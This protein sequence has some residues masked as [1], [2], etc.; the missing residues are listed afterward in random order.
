MAEDFGVICDGG[1]GRPLDLL[2]ERTG[3]EPTVMVDSIEDP[4]TGDHHTL[5]YCGPC[6]ERLHPHGTLLPPDLL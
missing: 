3:L 4:F 5:A 2:N 1:C 6:V